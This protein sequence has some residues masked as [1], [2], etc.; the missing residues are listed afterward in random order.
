MAWLFVFFTANTAPNCVESC[1]E[2][3]SSSTSVHPSVKS[4]VKSYGP[5]P[6]PAVHRTAYSFGGVGQSMLGANNHRPGWMA[7]QTYCIVLHLLQRLLV[8]YCPRFQAS[9]PNVAPLAWPRN[10]IPKHPRSRPR[11]AACHPILYRYF[12]S[13]PRLSVPNGRR[14]EWGFVILQSISTV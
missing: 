11:W 13:V 6:L 8:S 7:R 9:E 2:T 1:G 14:K 10:Q 3:V 5:G 4:E 12:G